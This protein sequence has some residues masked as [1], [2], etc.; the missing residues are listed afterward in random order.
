MKGNYIVDENTMNNHTDP[1]LFFSRSL[2]TAAGDQHYQCINS[3]I[4][5]PRCIEYTSHYK[6][7]KYLKKLR[8]K[9]T[10]SLSLS[11]HRK[12]EDT[13]STSDKELYP[14]KYPINKLGLLTLSD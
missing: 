9:V 1:G 7:V 10:L 6:T 12:I 11:L 3:S 2:Y 13:D 14:R 4:G 8:D 5:A